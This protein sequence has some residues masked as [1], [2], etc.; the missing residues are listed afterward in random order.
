VAGAFVHESNARDIALPRFGGWWG[1]DPRTRFRMQLEPDFVPVPSADGWQVSNPAILA[2]APLRA[3]LELFDRAGMPALRAKSV[4][5]TNYLHD[6]LVQ[7]A[8]HHVDVITPLDPERRGCQLS[9]RLREGALT[10]QKSLAERG[11]IGDFRE[12]DILRVAPTPLYNTFHDSWLLSQ[13]L[14]GR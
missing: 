5:L 2:M 12:P 4:R 8:G 14:S 6:L 10:A 9:L 11:F 3:S 13:A 1:N 7:V